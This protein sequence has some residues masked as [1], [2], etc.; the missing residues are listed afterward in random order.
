ML[1]KIQLIILGLSLSDLIASYFYINIF[2][3]KYP[4]QDPTIIE[5]NII[6]KLFI[7]KLG[8]KKGMIFGELIIFAIMLLI[9]LNINSNSQYFLLGTLSMMLIYHLLNFNLLK[10]N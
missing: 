5:A 9:V 2:H 8:I 3:K 7:K 10:T 4:K 1:N 6:I